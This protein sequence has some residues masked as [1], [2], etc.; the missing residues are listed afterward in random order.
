MY[1]HAHMQ[2]HACARGC[3]IRNTH[4]R[5]HMACAERWVDPCE[6]K[7]RS[8]DVDMDASIRPEEVQQPGDD[9]EPLVMEEVWCPALH[10]RQVH[11]HGQ[12]RC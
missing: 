10:K 1:I 3:V 12:W 7:S 11:V 5:T 6:R 8:K 2:Y 9:K 4:K